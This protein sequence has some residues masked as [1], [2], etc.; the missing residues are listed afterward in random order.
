MEEI[1]ENMFNDFLV[2]TDWQ[3]NNKFTQL[4]KNNISNLKLD[5]TDLNTLKEFKH[6]II[7]RR[8]VEEHGRLMRFLRAGELIDTKLA[9]LRAKSK[10][11]KAII[12][13]YQPEN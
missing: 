3:R 6:I 13:Q 8:R 1:T 12:S 9:D 7:N 4:M 10:D 2:A 5:L 11:A